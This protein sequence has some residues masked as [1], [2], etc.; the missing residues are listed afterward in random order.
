MRDVPLRER[1]YAANRGETHHDRH[2]R[3]VLIVEIERLKLGDLRREPAVEEIGEDVR[4]QMPTIRIQ[5][6]SR[7][8][9]YRNPKKPACASMFGASIERPQHW[10]DQKRESIDRSNSRRKEKAAVQISP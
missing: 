9:R 5:Q 7:P 4:V 1:Q 8:S 10:P 6:S 3:R 2:L